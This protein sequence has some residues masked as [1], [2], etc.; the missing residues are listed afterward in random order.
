MKIG[1]IGTGKMAKGL[2]RRWANAGHEVLFGSR[3][4]EKAKALATEI[5][6]N[7]S[8]G[9]QQEAVNFSDVIVLAVPWDAAEATLKSLNGLAGKTLIETTNNFVDRNPVSTTER[10]SG[11]AI[12]AKVVKAF[13]GVFWQIL[14]GDP[15]AQA[16]ADV[17]IAGDDASAKQTTAQLVTD[18]GFNAVD[19]GGAKNAHF[20]EEWAFLVIEL[21]YGQ[22]MGTNIGLKVMKV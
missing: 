4:A 13:N 22:G 9:S 6:G 21:A 5:G 10:I 16:R 12:G 17:L 1:I 11:W 7:A 8:G 14:H 3:D 2:G 20:L 15:A 19:M 18:A